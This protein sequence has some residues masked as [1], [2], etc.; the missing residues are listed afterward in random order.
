ME[1]GCLGLLI[2]GF[3]AFILIGLG[4]LI[5]NWFGIIGLIIY[6]ILIFSTKSI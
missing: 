3:W 2:L 6:I 5:N 1:E 4:I